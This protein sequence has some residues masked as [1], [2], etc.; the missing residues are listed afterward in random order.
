MRVEWTEL[1]SLYLSSHITQGWPAWLEWLACFIQRHYQQYTQ[2]FMH[3]IT[4]QP[5]AQCSPLPDP[6]RVSPHLLL[7]Q[8]QLKLQR[9][10]QLE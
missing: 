6:N 9:Q 8:L 7:L 5:L 2:V 10:L 3:S 4:H 1:I